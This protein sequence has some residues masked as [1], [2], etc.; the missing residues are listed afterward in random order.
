MSGEHDLE[1]DKSCANSADGWRCS[2]QIGSIIVTTRSF[3]DLQTTFIFNYPCRESM[4]L[5][6]SNRR[7][8]VL[9]IREGQ[10]RLAGSLIKV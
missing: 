7:L 5:H 9:G 3:I 2:V 1:A 8:L 4:V 10:S 6:T